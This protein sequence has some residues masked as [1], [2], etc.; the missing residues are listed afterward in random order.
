M[1]IVAI[2]TCILILI[3]LSNLNVKKCEYSQII[4]SYFY[5]R[6][7]VKNNEKNNNIVNWIR[8][9]GIPAVSILLIGLIC[10]ELAHWSLILNI[11]ESNMFVFGLVIIALCVYLFNTEFI[12]D[13]IQYY[14][15]QTMGSLVL[16][17]I[18]FV[19][20][21]HSIGNIS[22]DDTSKILSILIFAVGQIVFIVSAISSYKNMYKLLMEKNRNELVQYLKNTDEA[23]AHRI[24]QIN[25]GVSEAKHYTEE[26][27][28]SWKK[29]KKNNVLD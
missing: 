2:I 4:L 25:E 1:S 27:K 8:W 17:V 5:L 22:E 19:A 16:F 28:D 10:N 20:Y 12:F 15:V 23:Y 3:I 29:M 14:K 13:K 21:I 18:M 24:E 26:F 11:S 6:T 9:I 7:Q